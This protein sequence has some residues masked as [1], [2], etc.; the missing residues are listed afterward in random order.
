M[1]APE[2]MP[3]QRIARTWPVNALSRLRS[4]RGTGLAQLARAAEGGGRRIAHGLDVV[5]L[6][7]LMEVAARVAERKLLSVAERKSP[8][9]S[10]SA[11]SAA[12]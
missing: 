3:T 7:L 1:T 9:K 6:G 4:G 12:R 5:A 11:Q 2:P 10:S 8:G